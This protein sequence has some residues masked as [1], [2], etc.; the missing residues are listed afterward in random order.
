MR[1]AA[2]KEEKLWKG[3]LQIVLDNSSPFLSARFE[4]YR[5]HR[6]RGEIKISQ[7]NA[8]N[9][10]YKIRQEPY[11]KANRSLPDGITQK[12]K[13]NGPPEGGNQ[14]ET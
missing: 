12:K 5:Y 7:N 3:S 4:Y 14:R 2:L 11:H 1:S 8:H 9:E 10:E 13:W 6:R